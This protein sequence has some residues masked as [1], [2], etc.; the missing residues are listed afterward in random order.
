M[1]RR[2]RQVLL[3]PVAPQA[4]RLE[5]AL[6]DGWRRKELAFPVV[7]VDFSNVEGLEDIDRTSLQAPHRI[8]DALLRDSFLGDTLFRQSEVGRVTDA[9]PAHAV[10][11]VQTL[12]HS[13]DLRDLG[14]HR[15]EKRIRVKFSAVLPCFGGRRCQ[16]DRRRQGGQS[17][18]PG[19]YRKKAGPVYQH[20]NH[21][22]EWT[23]DLEEAAKA[24]GKTRF[25]FH[26]SA[27]PTRIT[28]C[29]QSR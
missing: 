5:E 12:P 18:R 25:H 8:A 13:F 26:A 24:K 14:Q 11:H 6:L 4:N 3:D 15:A 28:I 1:A 23:T 10:A 21:E 19:W 2:P 7:E 16:R 17:Y 9:R 27:R 29:N 20:K 22:E